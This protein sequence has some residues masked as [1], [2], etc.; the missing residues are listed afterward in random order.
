M[1]KKSITVNC[2]QNVIH[3][4]KNNPPGKK[5]I[6]TVA[7]GLRTHELIYR[8]YGEVRTD[9]DGNILENKKGYIQLLPKGSG[10]RKYEVETVETGECFDVFFDTD[11]PFE[12]D[13]FS[14]DT[15]YSE[16]LGILFDQIHRTWLKKDTGYYYE[17]KSIL[18]RI[19]AILQRFFEENEYSKPHY[20]K[21][22]PAV[23]YLNEN[24]CSGELDI[25]Y[26]AEL[27]KMSYSYFRRLFSECM[28]VSPGK[29]VLDKRI[30]R[31]KD[32][33]ATR[34]FNVSETAELVGFC[35]VYHFSHIF[36]KYTGHSPG[37]I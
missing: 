37:K 28:G 14:V 13:P 4:K 9:I 11:I 36:K 26:A 16:E 34:Q 5:D 35:D 22:A 27:C 8:I 29:Y 33:L 20:K 23:E 21:I 1:F 19:I 7:D 2:I 15:G 32:L 24:F 6:Y 3:V 10:S 12:A 31:A 25:E 30:T 18:Y 17:A